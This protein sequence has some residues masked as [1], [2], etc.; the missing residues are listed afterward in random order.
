V[1]PGLLLTQSLGPAGVTAA[2]LLGQYGIK[3]LAIE[4]EPSVYF[5]P[6]AAAIDDEVV[7]AFQNLDRADGRP[8]L[9]I[10][11]SSKDLIQ[12]NAQLLNRCLTEA[13]EE[14]ME[15]HHN[16]ESVLKTWQAAAGSLLWELPSRFRE[17][18]GYFTLNFIHQPG[19]EEKLRSVLQTYSSVD[20]LLG[21]RVTDILKNENDEG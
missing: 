7:R 17:Q 9:N 14:E 18:N 8:G 3:T 6:R 1:A 15:K 10:N 19:L 16:R 4:K 5:C 20:S 2:I 11:E 21:W 12:R 13:E